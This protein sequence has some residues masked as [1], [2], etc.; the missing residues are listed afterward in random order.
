MLFRSDIFGYSAHRRSE[1]AHI[2]EYEALVETVLQ[3]LCAANHAIGIKLAALPAK[4]RGFDVVKDKGMAEA[5]QLKTQWLAEFHAAA[6]AP[7]ER[8]A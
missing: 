3:G 4:V 8:A 1:R 2:G 7:A 5:S 6:A